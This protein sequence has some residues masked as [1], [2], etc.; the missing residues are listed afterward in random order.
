MSIQHI[1]YLN[2]YASVSPVEPVQ[3]TAPSAQ[4]N[5]KASETELNRRAARVAREAFTVHLSREAQTRM[6]E[7]SCKQLNDAR[8]QR[9]QD[10]LDSVIAREF[11][12]KLHQAAPAQS[13]QDPLSA[14][15]TSRIVNIIA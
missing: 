7:E 13:V 11:L 1:N 15:G 6:E 3:D 4:Q 9:E 12:E 2:P 10:S 8:A 5:K 14:R